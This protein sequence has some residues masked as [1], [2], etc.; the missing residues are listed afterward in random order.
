MVSWTAEADIVV[1]GSGATGIPS[2]IVAREAG[3]SVILIEAEAEWL[4]S[5]LG[6][7]VA[8]EPIPTT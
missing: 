5:W 7:R 6:G 3:C 1:V 8:A 4:P 2:A